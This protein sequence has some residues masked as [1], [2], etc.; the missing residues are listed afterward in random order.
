MAEMRLALVTFAS[1]KPKMVKAELPSPRAEQLAAPH[2]VVLPYKV[3]QK[4]RAPTRVMLKM[5]GA[6]RAVAAA[7]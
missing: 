5:E 4:R 7:R 1:Y 6:R 3:P 2:A